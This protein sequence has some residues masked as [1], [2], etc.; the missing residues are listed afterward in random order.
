MMDGDVDDDDV[1]DDDDDVDDI[2]DGDDVGFAI[3]CSLCHDIML[4]GSL[5]LCVFTA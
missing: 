5:W 4:T 2:L 1:D 3:G